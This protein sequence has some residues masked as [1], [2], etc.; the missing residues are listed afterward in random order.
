VNTT[1]KHQRENTGPYS[2]PRSKYVVVPV[3]TANKMV[4]HA[5]P[6]ENQNQNIPMAYQSAESEPIWTLPG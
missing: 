6:N 3:A 5:V 1:H 4:P 2:L